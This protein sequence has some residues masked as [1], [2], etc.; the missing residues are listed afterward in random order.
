M[1]GIISL[2][3]SIAGFFVGYFIIPLRNQRLKAEDEFI[4]LFRELIEDY[5]QY[6]ILSSN[7]GTPLT[8]AKKL[9]EKI[10][11][12]CE[13][14]ILSVRRSRKNTQ[15]EEVINSLTDFIN[16]FN[17]DNNKKLIAK[18]KIYIKTFGDNYIFQINKQLIIK[19]QNNMKKVVYYV[20]LCTLWIIA[21]FALAF[22]SVICG[23]IP[24]SLGVG[25]ALGTGCGHPQLWLI[26]IG[27]VLL[28]RPVLYKAIFKEHKHFKRTVAIV[29]ITFGLVWFAMNFG[30]RL[31]NQAAQKAVME[32]FEEN[33]DDVIDYTPGMFNEQK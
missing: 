26:A 3:I 15:S 2:C 30:A 11:A 29:L 32:R 18:C 4:V 9:R 17:D 19:H 7:N 14:M 24:L 27:I 10:V 21:L 5:S 23:F 8:A 28:L 31:Y 33:E 16:E 25:A 12:N 6:Q 1:L 20:G 22:V 13:L